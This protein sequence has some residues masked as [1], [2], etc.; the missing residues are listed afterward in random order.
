MAPTDLRH[1]ERS[2]FKQYLLITF[3]YW[4]FT[5][6]DGA[7]RMLVVLYFHQLG[8]SAL[9]IALLFIFYELFGVITNLFGGWL[10]SRLGLNQTMNIGL[11]LQI[12]ALGMLA[13]P[14][15]DLSVF[16]VMLAQA[17]SGIAKDL[18]KM[19]AK[20]GV[21]FLVPQQ[22]SSTLYK[23]VARLTGS[24]NSLKGIGFF[25]G[26]LLLSFLGFQYAVAL[27]ASALT[28]IWII[29][30]VFLRRELGIAK[31]KPELLKIFAKSEAINRLSLARF[32]LFGARDIWFVI[33]LPVYLSSSQGWLH[34]QIG[35][36]MACWVILYGIAQTQAPNITAKDKTPTSTSATK[37]AVILALIPA[38]IALCL[39]TLN[40]STASL[41]LG[42]FVFGFVFAINSSIHSFLIIQYADSEAVSMD[43]GFYYMANAAGR[44]TGTLLSGLIFQFSGLLACLVGSSIMLALAAYAASKITQK[45]ISVHSTW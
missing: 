45:E 3:N 27:M 33:A 16:W 32:F 21:K 30:L 41:I 37:W 31:N 5:I 4:A 39:F 23:W 1:S 2:N 9:E 19:S 13:V 7:L 36:F 44:L 8:Y 24:K 14:P 20:S 22:E 15:T 42:L 40:S 18:N 29:S 28:V 25:I 34:E 10:G 26:A 43:V 11:G 6:T 17:I 12:C 38:G 35:A